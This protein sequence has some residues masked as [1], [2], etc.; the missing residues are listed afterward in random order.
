[1]L[2]L[3]LADRRYLTAIAL[4]ADQPRRIYGHGLLYQWARFM[5]DGRTL[6][7]AGAYPQQPLRLYLQTVSGGNPAPVRTGAY[8]DSF[9]ISPDGV[10]VAG[11][12]A[13]R[14]PVIVTLGTDALRT[15]PVDSESLPAGWTAD[16]RG[17][18]LANVSAPQA[19][20]MLLNIATGETRTVRTFTAVNSLGDTVVSN[21]VVTPNGEYYVYSLD[22]L[23]SQVFSLD[24]VSG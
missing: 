8:I 11:L 3:D 22:H 23:A 19:K 20:L 16:G 2:A 1:V 9:V 12:T 4:G 21:M 18:Y 15:L 5:P 6:L 13:E 17:L 24:G 10:H 14:R 7:A